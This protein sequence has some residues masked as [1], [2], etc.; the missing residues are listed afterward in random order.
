MADCNASIVIFKVV[1]DEGQGIRRNCATSGE[2]VGF[3]IF[4]VDYVQ[5]N[6]SVLCT[7]GTALYF[8]LLAS[9]SVLHANGY[10]INLK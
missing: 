8:C 7:C 9:F 1:F 4:C 10:Q 2:A 3:T 5:D 6:A